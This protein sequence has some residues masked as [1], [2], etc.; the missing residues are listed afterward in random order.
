MISWSAERSLTAGRAIKSAGRLEL[1]DAESDLLEVCVGF[2]EIIEEE[3]F[4]G[5]GDEDFGGQRAGRS[6]N[7]WR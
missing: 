7:S 3:A 6:A 1:E 4:L 2:S 5:G